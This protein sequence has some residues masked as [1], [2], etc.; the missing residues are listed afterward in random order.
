MQSVRALGGHEIARLTKAL[1]AVILSVDASRISAIA[2]LPNVVSI[3]P[4]GVYQLDLSETVPY[5][6]AK[7]VQDAGFKGDGVTVAVLD[8]GID[9]THKEFGGPG[10]VDAYQAA[11]R[12]DTRDA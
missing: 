4:V 1:N 6:G 7:A 10:N 5:I 12:A 11:E 8:T 3:R 9:Y 2:G